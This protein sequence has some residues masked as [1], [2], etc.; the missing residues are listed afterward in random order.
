MYDDIEV[1][2]IVFIVAIALYILIASVG[3]A[4]EAIAGG[5]LLGGVLAAGVESSA[6]VESNTGVESGVVLGGKEPP[7]I[8]SR[9]DNLKD[10]DILGGYDEYD[11]ES[12]L[13]A[14]ASSVDFDNLVVDGNNFLYQSVKNKADLA[15]MKGYLQGIRK[16]VKLLSK[17]FPKKNLYI[18]LKDPDSDRQEE[19]LIK[20]L[21]VDNVRSAHKSF[22]DSIVK[23]YPKVR[24][25]VAY[26]DAK[27]RDDYAA[28]WLADSLPNVALLSRD[29]YRDVSEMES[30]KVKFKAYGKGASKINKLINKPFSYVSSGAVKATLIGYTFSKTLKS[31]FYEKAV[32]KRSHASDMV[33][34]FN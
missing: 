14:K 31:G 6:G 16:M 5:V 27:Y 2:L 10:V 12:L 11:D 9:P 26:G 20:E 34:V 1:V 18:V 33:Y 25:V 29:R 3:V 21:K 30:N 24:F 32:N 7:K 28:I 17:Y 23:E 19:E 22:F 15:R 8:M 13:I 4:P